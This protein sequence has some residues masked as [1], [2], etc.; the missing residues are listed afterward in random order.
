MLD[1][2]RQAFDELVQG[3]AI[4]AMAKNDFEFALQSIDLHGRPR[5]VGARV[6]QDHAH[7]SQTSPAGAGSRAANAAISWQVYCVV[8]M[9]LRKRASATAKQTAEIAAT[10]SRSGQTMEKSAPR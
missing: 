10:A 6:P 3:F 8:T 5:Q 9:V 7:D 2:M 4:P 1:R